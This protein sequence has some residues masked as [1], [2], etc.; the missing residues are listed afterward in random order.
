MYGEELNRAIMLKQ[1]QQ[2]VEKFNK[3]G[4]RDNM[5]RAV[6]EKGFSDK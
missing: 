2:D 6:A 4:E 3:I 1:Q 5:L